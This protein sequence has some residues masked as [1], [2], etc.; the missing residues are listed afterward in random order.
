MAIFHI[1]ILCLEL[2]STT[3][4]NIEQPTWQAPDM[5]ITPHAFITAVVLTAYNNT[6]LSESF[7]QAIR[8]LPCKKTQG[9]INISKT[10]N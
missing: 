1:K 5:H 9:P 8:V 10:R 6:E 2:S 7:Q 4:Q 3:K